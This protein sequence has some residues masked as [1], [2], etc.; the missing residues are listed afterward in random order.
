M[1]LTFVLSLSK[2]QICQKTDEKIWRLQKD[3]N[4]VILLCF[5]WDEKLVKIESIPYPGNQWF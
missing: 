2:Q 5:T 1:M 4:Q 3:K